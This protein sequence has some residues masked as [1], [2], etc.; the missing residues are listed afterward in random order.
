MIRIISLLI[1]LGI[2]VAA[3]AQENPDKGHN[4]SLGFQLNSIQ[5]DF[6]LGVQT[7]SPYFL[8]KKMAIR[9]HG[10]YMYLQHQSN[11][12]T[13]WSPY[14]HMQLGVVSS[15]AIASGYIRLYG[16]GGVG[17]LL[18][19]SQFSQTKQ[20]VTGYGV[21]GFEFFFAPI[22]YAPGSYFFEAGGIG[23]GAVADKVPRKPIYSNGFML[24]TG[25]RFYL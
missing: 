3:K 2:A 10:N 21:F 4:M 1:A 6:G 25:L 20:H 8:H 19:N 15:T 22:S 14:T 18:P 23:S 16:E 12:E 7:T 13:I 9:L 11:E 17:L 5:Q 24:R